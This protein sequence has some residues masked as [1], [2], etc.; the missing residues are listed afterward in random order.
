[1]EIVVILW[2][3]WYS[4]NKLLHEG[5]AQQVCHVVTFVRSYYAEVATIDKGLECTKVSSDSQ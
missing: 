3:L 4:R 5:K 1:M 2:A